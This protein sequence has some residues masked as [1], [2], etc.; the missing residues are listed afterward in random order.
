LDLAPD[1]VGDVDGSAVDAEVLRSLFLDGGQNNR[2]EARARVVAQR[3]QHLDLSRRVAH[4]QL[5]RPASHGPHSTVAA[6]LVLTSA[7]EG[8]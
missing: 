2:V 8:A 5:D 3:Q 1:V 7:G 4:V 6:D